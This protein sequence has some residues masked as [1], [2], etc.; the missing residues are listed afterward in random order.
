MEGQGTGRLL[1]VSPQGP[2]L[3][4]AESALVHS[5]RH[6]DASETSVNAGNDPAVFQTVVGIH[7]RG[8]GKDAT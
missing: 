1:A 4:D 2:I 3:L 5:A 7:A 6:F 8:C